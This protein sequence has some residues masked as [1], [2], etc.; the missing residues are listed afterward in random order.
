M[1][2]IRDIVKDRFII[3]LLGTLL[4]GWM[5]IAGGK[6]VASLAPAQIDFGFDYEKSS[7]HPSN[8]VEQKLETKHYRVR[9]LSFPSLG[10]NGQRGNLVK[11]LYYQSKL[12]G[13]KKLVIVLPIWGTS[14]YPSR[15]I[16]KSLLRYS[17]GDI[18]VLR[19]LGEDFLFDWAAM[20]AAASE[21]ALIAVAE[22]MVERVRTH[23]RDVR[24]AIDWAEAQPGVD[25]DRIG[26]IGFSMGAIVGS[27]I[28]ANEP[29]IAAT[30]LAM[31]GANTHEML[32]NCF[33]RAKE[34][35]EAIMAR[36]GWTKE[37]FEE[38][39]ARPL[40]PINAARFAGSVNPDRVI[41]FEAERDRCIPKSSREALWQAMGQ[42]QRVSLANGH[43]MAFLAMTP[44]G[45]NTMRRKIYD[46][47]EETLR[48]PP[49][50]LKT[51]LAGRD[52]R[53]E[54]ASLR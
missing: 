16:T 37:A 7:I 26:L 30:V 38:K 8:H 41:I 22:R 5:P 13:K 49:A 11:A 12:P 27:L 44:L 50:P 47:L 42:P 25:A 46:F 1:F 53:L 9:S 48:H 18:N 10:D 51:Q 31:G 32:A 15:K 54:A 28:A 20:R 39:L 21:A 3:L 23:V 14:T 52:P 4:V 45:F 35:R 33:G 34:T 36:L 40:M 29:R 19:I 2:H 24:R 6:E 17:R 43:K